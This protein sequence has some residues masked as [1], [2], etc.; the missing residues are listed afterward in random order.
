M[1]NKRRSP[2]E[3]GD[4]ISKGLK[5]YFETHDNP[6]KGATNSEETRAKQRAAWVRKKARPTWNEGHAERAAKSRA[7]WTP[8]KRKDQ[9]E[10]MKAAH[11]SGKISQ[12]MQKNP[13]WKGGRSLDTKGYVLVRRWK[14]PNAERSGYVREHRLVMSEYLGRPLRA[15]E[16][17][18]HVNGIKSDNRIENLQIVIKGRGPHG[19][20]NCPFCHQIFRVM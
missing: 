15:S 11:R 10:R 4:K 3:W 9:S 20:V 2:K 8:R 14:H 1:D 16:L 18:H 5:R 13:L 7:W 17:V 6:R 19:T 12:R